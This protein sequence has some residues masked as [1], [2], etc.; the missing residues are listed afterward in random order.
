MKNVV[1][2]N[3]VETYQKIDMVSF[4]SGSKDEIGE[5]GWRYRSEVGA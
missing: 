2:V 5:L 4:P 1:F 3:V